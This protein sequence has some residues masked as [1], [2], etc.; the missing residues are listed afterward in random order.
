MIY[1]KPEAAFLGE[2]VSLIRGSG[3]SLAIDAGSSQPAVQAD[4][5]LDD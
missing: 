5:D 4:C 3:K 1:E 2:A